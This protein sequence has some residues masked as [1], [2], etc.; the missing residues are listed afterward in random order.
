MTRSRDEAW[1]VAE[2]KRRRMLSGRSGQVLEVELG[3]IPYLVGDGERM[4]S[5]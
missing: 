4:R 1:L 5:A 2:T 3:F